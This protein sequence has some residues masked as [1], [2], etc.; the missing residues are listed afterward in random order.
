M[1]TRQRRRGPRPKIDALAVAAALA[2]GE[3]AYALAK[4]LGVDPTAIYRA[5]DRARMAVL[6]EL[7]QTT[8]TNRPS[9]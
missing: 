9:A 3:G 2:E 5:R 1:T 8:L 6:T 4:R 7:H